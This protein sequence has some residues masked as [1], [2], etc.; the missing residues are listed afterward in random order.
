MNHLLTIATLCAVLAVP[1]VT[2]ARQRDGL[3]FDGETFSADLQK[4]PLSR[5]MGDFAAISGTRVRWLMGP[6]TEEVNRT[7]DALP[8]V[9]AIERLLV[10]RNYAVLRGSDGARRIWIGALKGAGVPA[11]HERAD[12]VVPAEEP[13]LPPDTFAFN[14]GTPP[15]A[16]TDD[17]VVAK[18]ESLFAGE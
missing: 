14:R 11:E 10:H 5:V 18:S 9:E 4:R 12:D 1:A 3:S 15:S 17:A 8:L 7:F 16:P 13:P 2:S 6:A